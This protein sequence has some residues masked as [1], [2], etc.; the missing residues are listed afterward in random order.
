MSNNENNAGLN[1]RGQLLN[2]YGKRY[3]KKFAGKP[4]PT[5]LMMH[6]T[7]NTAII[8]LDR[9]QGLTPEDISRSLRISCVDSDFEKIARAF[10]VQIELA[11][12][13]EEKFIWDLYQFYNGI[14]N[15]IRKTGQYQ[16]IA[17]Y[18]GAYLELDHY[19]YNMQQ[20]D[21]AVG[22]FSNLLLHTMEYLRPEKFNLKQELI[23]VATTGEPLAGDALYP[24]FDMPGFRLH[25]TMGTDAAPRSEAQAMAMTAAVYAE[26]GLEIKTSEDMMYY[27]T[28]QRGYENSL[29]IMLRYTNEYTSDM[30]PQKPYLSQQAPCAGLQVNFPPSMFH[31]VLK[32]RSSTLP[33]NGVKIVADDV[34]SEIQAI[35]MKE[36]VKD[37]AVILLYRIETASG[38]ISGYYNTQTDFLYSIT[39][40]IGDTP[41]LYGHVSAMVLYCYAKCVVKYIGQL[42][43][44]IS[45]QMYPMDFE[46]EEL[47]DESEIVYSGPL[48]PR[49]DNT[50]VFLNGFIRKLPA[51]ETASDEDIALAAGMGYALEEDEVYVKPPCKISFVKKEEE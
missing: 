42:D 26:Q 50:E 4:F 33:K 39:N 48:S 11:V 8:V 43:V 40:E 21:M 49:E 20:E 15:Q 14:S 41:D 34:V 35:Y 46:I 29:F 30:L 51:G 37:D 25:E 9:L 32:R 16:Q 6:R 3:R 2:K 23:G 18:T 44:M 19:Y 17:D 27:Q 5:Q 36:I 47:G 12:V 22:A 1:F 10:E 13:N 45:N 38:D 7:F 28:A 24:F 31:K